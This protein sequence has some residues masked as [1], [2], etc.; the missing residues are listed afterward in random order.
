MKQVFMAPRE[1]LELKPSHGAPCTRCGL[2]CMATLCPLGEH[3]F[4]FHFGPCPALEKT[5]DGFGCGVVSRAVA[6][7]RQDMADAASLLIGSGTG[8]DAR[9][10]GEPANAEFYAELE[11]M[12][13]RME[14]ETKAAKELWR[15]RNT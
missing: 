14:K 13:V 6:K 1:L 11:A 5:K 9:F 15:M 10:N 3:I 7:G 4:G 12:D 2:C 8:C